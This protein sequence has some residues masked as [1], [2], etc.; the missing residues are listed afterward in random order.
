MVASSLVVLHV[1]S[2]LVDSSH[3]LASHRLI[4]LSLHSSHRTIGLLSHSHFVSIS[5]VSFLVLLCSLPCPIEGACWNQWSQGFMYATSVFCLLSFVPQ[6]LISNA[7]LVCRLIVHTRCSYVLSLCTLLLANPHCCCHQGMDPKRLKQSLLWMQ[8][9]LV[10][11]VNQG[12][13]VKIFYF[14]SNVLTCVTVNLF[15]KCCNHIQLHNSSPF[16]F[17]L[18]QKWFP[19]DSVL[20]S[21]LVQ[22]F[23]LFGKTKPN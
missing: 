10:H 18:L 22:F 20:K 2:H 3:F 19:T 6:S 21:G 8:G 13:W 14:L 16:P 11:A 12:P 9:I 5:H 15:A 23:C 1:I 4:G 7:S 17:T